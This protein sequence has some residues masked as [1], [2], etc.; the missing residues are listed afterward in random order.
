MGRLPHVLAHLYASVDYD[1]AY[2]ALAEVA[3]L[4]RFAAV[5]SAKLE[6]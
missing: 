5:A 3:N 2:D 4:E 6:A 1:R